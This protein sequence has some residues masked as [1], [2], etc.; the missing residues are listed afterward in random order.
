MVIISDI[1]LPKNADGILKVSDVST[2]ADSD[3]SART[4]ITNPS[5][6]KFVKTDVDGR[7]NILESSVEGVGVDNS[8]NSTAYAVKQVGAFDGTAFRSVKCSNVGRLEVDINSGGGS[9]AS[10]AGDDTNNSMAAVGVFASI[11]GTADYRSIQVDSAGALNVRLDGSN[12]HVRITGL[13]SVGANKG[14][15]VEDTDGG[16]LGAG[17]VV[18]ADPTS[19]D[20]SRQLLRLNAK[21]ELLINNSKITQGADQTL[22]SAQQVLVYGEVTSG[23]GIGDLHP[24]HITQSG[25]VEVVIADLEVKGQDTMSNSLPVAISSDQSTLNVKTS[26]RETGNLFTTTTLAGSSFTATS[27]TNLIEFKQVRIFGENTNLTNQPTL[28]IY[29]SLSQNSG[30]Y[31]LGFTNGQI[32]ADSVTEGG[33]TKYYYNTVL[34]NPPPYIRIFNDSVSS[35][36]FNLDYIATNI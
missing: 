5:T 10:K 24:I 11:N 23:A 18:V 13:N 20:G 36:D 33:T 14:V 29:G 17:K 3:L 1:Q 6:S 21:N 28:Y 9:I 2:S 15:G 26:P 25:D 31:F 34:D 27:L 16:I 35:T 4:D 32:F 7:L 30:F 8:L 22:S 19:A 12:D